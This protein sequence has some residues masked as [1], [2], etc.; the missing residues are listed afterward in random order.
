MYVLS[1]P[2]NWTKETSENKYIMKPS[3]SQGFLWV[4]KIVLRFILHKLVICPLIFSFFIPSIG[5]QIC[6]HSLSQYF[7][8]HFSVNFKVP[9]LH[10]VFISLYTGYYCPNGSYTYTQCVYPY[11]CPPGTGEPLTCDI[12]YQPLNVSGLRDSLDKACD[13]C[14]PGS[15]R[16]SS[17]DDKCMPCP[18]GYYCPEGTQFKS[19]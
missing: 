18:P 1:F 5:I 16:N 13:I 3:N 8:I 9:F 11:Y 12:G 10:V 19:W 2:L 15:Y 7:L 4:L 14:P 6:E 17:E